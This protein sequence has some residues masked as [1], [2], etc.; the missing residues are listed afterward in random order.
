MDVL[1]SC[2]LVD[3]HFEEWRDI[4]LDEEEGGYILNMSDSRE[5]GY[6]LS[7]TSSQLLF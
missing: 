3:P 7:Q 5:A 6:L 2:T 4:A 1:C